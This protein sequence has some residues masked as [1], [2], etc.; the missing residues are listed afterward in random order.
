MTDQEKALENLTHNLK[1][2]RTMQIVAKDL[3]VKIDSRLERYV[4]QI[5]KYTAEYQPIIKYHKPS[6]GEWP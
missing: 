2:I 3:M 5:D 4:E 6:R 1:G